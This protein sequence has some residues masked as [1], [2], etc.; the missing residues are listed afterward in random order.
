MYING[1]QKL[2][3]KGFIFLF[4][5]DTGDFCTNVSFDL[6]ISDINHDLALLSDYF[7]INKLSLDVGKFTNI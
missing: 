6:N 7:E 5:D 4:A 3:L 2:P 1:I